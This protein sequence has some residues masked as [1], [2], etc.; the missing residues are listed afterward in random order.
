MPE[1]STGSTPEPGQTDHTAAPTPGAATAE[2]PSV[3]GRSATNGIHAQMSDVLRRLEEA[4]AAEGPDGASQGGL[5]A[6]ADLH[7]EALRATL[8]A[9]REAEE[10]LAHATKVHS[11]ATVQAEKILREAKGVAAGVHAEARTE[12]ARVREEMTRWAAERRSSLES[13]IGALLEAARKEAADLRADA[14]TKA[15]PEAEE[16]A[17]RYVA[18]A[19]A[20]GEQD[21]EAIRDEARSL[22]GSAAEALVRAQERAAEL[23]EL[24]SSHTTL[25]LEQVTELAGLADAARARAVR[26]TPD[27]ASPAATDPAGEGSVAVVTETT[28]MAASA[29]TRRLPRQRTSPEGGPLGSVFGQP[30][31]EGS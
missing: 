29:E 19:V 14:L 2:A 27:G 1:T 30:G 13:D 21:A 11:D 25:L 24:L 28:G 18:M 10:M 31:P 5:A 22:L 16:T 3:P 23:G 9:K 7:A 4:G 8:D 12:S 26:R 15:M 17:R 6:A 20:A